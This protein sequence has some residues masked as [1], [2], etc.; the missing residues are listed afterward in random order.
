M[1]VAISQRACSNN[2]NRWAEI[3]FIRR[4]YYRQYSISICIMK[5]V[6]V[7]TFRTLVNFIQPNRDIICLRNCVQHMHH[8]VYILNL[9]SISILHTRHLFFTTLRVYTLLHSMFG[10]LTSQSNGINRIPM[11]LLCLCLSLYSQYKQNAKLAVW[12]DGNAISSQDNC[13]STKSHNK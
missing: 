8:C 3:M 4:R 11:V 13:I 1:V 2:L 12:Q 9:V 7:C 6:M 5:M 10:T